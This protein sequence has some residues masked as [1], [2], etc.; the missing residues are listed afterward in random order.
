MTTTAVK[1]LVDLRPGAVDHGKGKVTFA[2][3]AP[4]K[5][6]VHLIGD[7]NGWSRSA[8]PLQS[9]PEGLWWL[10]KKL[11]KGAY[12]YQFLVNGKLVI[13]DPYA[14][15]LVEDS[16]YDP[17]RALIEV[18]RKPFVWRHDAWQRPAFNELII[19]ELH[20]G[21]F[22]PQGTFQGVI[23]KLDY[24]RDLG[25]NA[26]EL[27]PM[28]EFAGEEGWG[29][30]PA[31]FFSVEKS[32]GTLDDFKRLPTAGASPLFWTWWWPTRRTATPLTSSTPTR[33]APGMAAASA[34]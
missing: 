17:P 12:A 33:I 11:K 32:Y 1:E 2:L 15:E 30:N 25:V 5:R 18:G 34:S 10:E 31:Y 24:L 28:F 19:Y 4:G 29:Y 23:E 7:F 13:C 9:T 14:T 21:D 16:A 27:M 8:D 26:L 22:T 20:V 6:S 3:Y